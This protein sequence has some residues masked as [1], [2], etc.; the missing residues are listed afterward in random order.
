[1]WGR[2]SGP[3]CTTPTVLETQPTGAPLP[4]TSETPSANHHQPTP[5][6]A[7]AVNVTACPLDTHPDSWYNYT[8]TY[9]D[10]DWEEFGASPCVGR[11]LRHGGRGCAGVCE[12]WALIPGPP[13]PPALSVGPR[14]Q[15]SARTASSASLS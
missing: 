1:M 3:T 5:R 12:R 4:Q 13:H 15:R 8:V 14:P 7:Q 11:A 10:S 2:M 9:Y 6:M